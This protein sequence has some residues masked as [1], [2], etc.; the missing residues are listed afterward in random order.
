[1]WVK[2]SKTIS[3]VKKYYIWKPR[4]CTCRNGKDLESTTR[5]SAITSDEIIEVTKT[6]AVPT[7]TF[8]MKTILTNFNKKK[9]TCKIENIYIL[10]TFLSFTVSL[11]VSL[12][13]LPYYIYC[14]ITVL[15][16]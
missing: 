5:D 9:V 1:M 4:T 13:L 8:S 2:K 10:L 7:K 12:Y 15:L 3:C 6:K 16:K 11:I 14:H